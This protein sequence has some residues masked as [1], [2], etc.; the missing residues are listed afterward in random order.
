MSH[1]MLTP[2]NSIINVST[3]VE[4]KLSKLNDAKRARRSSQ[5]KIDAKAPSEIA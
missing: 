4:Q 1:E 2:L 3:F 5:R